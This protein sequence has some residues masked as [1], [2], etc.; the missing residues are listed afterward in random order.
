MDYVDRWAER[1]GVYVRYCDDLVCSSARPI[2]VYRFARFYELSVYYFNVLL[3]IR[4]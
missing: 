4:I 2:G 1:G 3:W